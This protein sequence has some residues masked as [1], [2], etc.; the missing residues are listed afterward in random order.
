[1]KKQNQYFVEEREIDL[2]KVLLQ[3]L[4][5][6]RLVLILAVLGAVLAVAADYRST[7]KE[8]TEAAI[9][10]ADKA[11][12]GPVTIESIEAKMD[13]YSIQR[14]WRFVY[15]TN[16]LEQRRAYQT[17]SI[18]MTL[19]PYQENVVDLS[20]EVVAEDSKAAENIANQYVSYIQS[21]EIGAEIK[22]QLGL[23]LQSSYITE[24][25]S[26]SRTDAVLKI[27][28]RAESEEACE[29]LADGV[30]SAVE[31]YASV[32]TASEYEL[33]QESRES[34]IVIDDEVVSRQASMN[35]DLA[36]YVSS[37]TA[38]QNSL[39]NEQQALAALILQEGITSQNSILPAE[40][41]TEE[42]ERA[43]VEP[44]AVSV[45][46]RPNKAP[47]GILG[48]ILLAVVCVVIGY[49]ASQGI[50]GM[51]EAK[52]LF[53]V[54]DMGSVSALS[55][56]KK[57]IGNGI[58]RWADKIAMEHSDYAQQFAMIRSNILL[59]CR[60]ENRDHVY[61]AGSKMN[62]VPEAF[63]TQLSDSLKEDGI[64]VEIG[65]NINRD[66]EALLK[67]TEDGA[68]V[69]V[70]ADEKSNCNEIAK[71]LNKCRENEVQL[72]GMVL[73]SNC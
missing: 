46:V 40:E 33:K 72:L 53:G 54:R 26:V 55:L 32:T 65:G 41:E 57:R 66:A 14:V 73:V 44:A 23:E 29:R 67:L 21:D 5:K 49:S 38:L 42:E 36:L 39:S 2:K 37:Y 9:A 17:E 1:M 61:L 15:M 19:N 27:R 4:K 8:A 34:N 63:L 10:A 60:K 3:V 69:L 24:L 64:T 31:G 48:G 68:C 28:V 18:L 20:Y 16:T 71:E 59:A 30:V 35:S 7:K 58:D 22:T 56:K 25:L 12:A 50:H 52:Y 11:N 51:Q 47:L 45:S 70:E 43:H 13:D 6:W 62:M